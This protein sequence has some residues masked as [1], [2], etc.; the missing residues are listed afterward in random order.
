MKGIYFIII[1]ELF[2]WILNSHWYRSLG[3]AIKKV[4]PYICG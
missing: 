4:R 3:N 2:P 1:M